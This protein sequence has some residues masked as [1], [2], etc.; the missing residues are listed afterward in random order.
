MRVEGVIETRI[1]RLTAELKGILATACVEGVAF[2]AEVVSQVRNLDVRQVVGALSGELARRHHLV[3]AGGVRQV[4]GRR[5]SRYRFSHS[6]FQRYLYSTLDPVERVHLHEAVGNALELL[7][8]GR[9]EVIAV[10][11]ARHFEEAGLLN[12]AMRYRQQ[13]GDAALRVYANPEAVAQY[14]R[15]VRLARRID[16]SSD[17]LTALYARL[18]RASELNSEYGRALA[19]YEEMEELARQRDDRSMELTSLVPQL[20]LHAE[21]TEVHDPQV[22]RALGERALS[23]AR[24]L[25]DWRAE[26]EILWGLS[27]ANFFANRPAEAI[28]R[29]ERSLAL[30]RELGLREQAA[31]TLNDLGCPIYLYSGRVSQAI[32]ALQEASDLW[33]ELGNRRML[34]SSLAGLS[35]AHMYGGEYERVIALSERALEIS[36]SNKDLWEQSKSLWALGEVYRQRGEYDRAIEAA[37]ESIRLG[38][39]GAFISSQT[40]T[41]ARLALAYADLGALNRAFALIEV[42]LRV[43]EGHKYTVDLPFIW[44]ILACLHIAAG[45]L[46]EA[47][48]MIEAA[49]RDPY[50]ESWVV[51]HFP[52]MIA[53]VKLALREEDL[54]RAAAAAD[55]LV[56]QLRRYGIR[57]Y[58]PEAL[59]L[60]GKAPLGLGRDD[61][62]YGRLVEAR[63]E[64]EALGARRTLWRVLDALSRLEDDPSRSQALRQAAREVIRYMVAHIDQDDLRA[65]FL[66]L[67]DVR[68]ALRDFE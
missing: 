37:K 39:S 31:R 22:G 15:A 13:A 38:E 46:P 12:K 36:R 26:T 4:A 48:H 62:A 61:A 2:T 24:E 64:A 28:D 21:P 52:V 5:I 42:A 8:Q 19:T 54:D 18:G 41:R 63:A 68:A 10:R 25:K 50:R 35:T 14:S 49:K 16:A 67:P 7:Y 6:L 30:A 29:G 56:S 9:T 65:S 20:A 1:D 66:S 55:D 59:Y 11:L 32:E 43:A 33:D 27:V 58:L 57:S 44:G 3:E 17:P 53:E 60:A 45:R 23:M 34:A 40:H 51:F 47:T